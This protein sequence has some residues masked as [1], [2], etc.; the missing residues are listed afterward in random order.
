MLCTLQ[1]LTDYSIRAT[2]GDL[3]HV[4]EFYFDHTTWNIRY[5]IVETGTWLFNR[6]VLIAPVA[7]GKP[8]WISGTIPVQLTGD[9]IRNSPPIDTER[10]VFRQHEAELAAYY[11]WPSYWVALAGDIPLRSEVVAEGASLPVSKQDDPRLRS[12]REIT[13]YIIRATD[14][15]IGHVD[16]FIIDEDAWSIVYIVVDTGNCLFVRK[17]LI[18]VKRIRSINWSDTT[19]YLDCSQETVKASPEYDPAKT[20]LRNYT[21]TTQPQA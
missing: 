8:D 7:I 5:L 18:A 1:E 13:G 19:V 14:G 17:V 12:T 15:T 4:R 6:K 11:H 20:I 21:V 9:Q 2:D 10:P 16:D 3:G